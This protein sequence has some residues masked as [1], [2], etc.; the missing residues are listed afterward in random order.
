MLSDFKSLAVADASGERVKMAL[1]SSGAVVAEI[2]RDKMAMEIFAESLSELCGGELGKVEAFALCTGPGSMLS[3]RVG[4]C[5]LSTISALTNAELFSW[6]CM[7]TAAFA[8]YKGF[9]GS[10]NASEKE[11]FKILAPSRKGFVN[12]L[13]FKGGEVALQEEAEIESAQDWGGLAFLL[14]Q[15]SKVDDRL[16]GIKRLDLTAKA[17]AMTLLSEPLLA[18]KCKAVPEPKSLSNREYVKWK[19]QARI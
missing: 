8:L 17:A 4:S 3:T 19:A 15:R 16:Q 12:V 13:D 7:Q 1:L 14:D 6:D 5:I 2:S 11:E 18:R 10:L 9:A